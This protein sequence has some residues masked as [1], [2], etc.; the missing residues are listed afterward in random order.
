[1]TSEPAILAY[2]PVILAV[3]A[4]TGAAVGFVANKINDRLK[5]HTF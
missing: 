4:A 2:A 3:G 5:L 1:L